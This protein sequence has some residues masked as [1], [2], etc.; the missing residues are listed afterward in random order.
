MPA[1]LSISDFYY[2]LPELVLTAGALL[3]L[4]VDVLL[5]R[6]SRLLTWV[7]VAVLLATAVSL[8]PFRTTHVEVSHGLIAVD[9]FGLFFKAIFL[10]AAIMTVLMSQRYLE[11]EGAIPGEY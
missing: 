11:I 9:R 6:G 3:L 1:G 5:P 2:I 10:V 4:V 7:A 8:I